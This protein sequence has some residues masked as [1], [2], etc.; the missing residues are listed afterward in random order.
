MKGRLARG[1]RA[2][3]RRRGS[4]D[5]RPTGA[6]AARRAETAPIL[7]NARGLPRR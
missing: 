6:D 3:R 4:A 2:M 5:G 1:G 7:P